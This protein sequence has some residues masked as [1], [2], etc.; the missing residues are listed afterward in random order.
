[1]FHETNTQNNNNVQNQTS[2]FLSHQEKTNTKKNK[3][4]LNGVKLLDKFNLSTKYTILSIVVGT[5]PVLVISCLT[6]SFGNKLISKQIRDFQE[7]QVMGLSN[8]VKSL[9]A[10]SY[11]DMGI[12]S[13]LA[14][15]PNNTNNY[16]GQ[17]S[18]DNLVKSS[19][20]YDSVSVF[21]INGNLIKYGGEYLETQL[22]LTDLNQ[23][24]QHNYPI[25]TPLEKV[26]NVGTVIYIIAPIKDENNNIV[27]IVKTRIPI[28]NLQQGLTGYL[29]NNKQYL[30]LDSAGKII[31]NSSTNSQGNNVLGKDAQTIYPKLSQII[32]SNNI[33]TFSTFS[34]NSQNQELVSYVALTTD[35]PDDLAKMNLRLIVTQSA[36][37]AFQN[38]REFL[39]FIIMATPLMVLCMTLLVAWLIQLITMEVLA[40]SVISDAENQ[41][42]KSNLTGNIDKND[43]K[44]RDLPYNIDNINQDLEL[45]ISDIH[46]SIEKLEKVRMISLLKPEEMMKNVE[47]CGEII[48]NIRF[49]FD[50]LQLAVSLINDA[51]GLGNKSR[52]LIEDIENTVVIEESL[53]IT[54]KKIK[55]LGEYAQQIA[56]MVASISQIAMQTNLLAINAGIEAARFGED[57]EGF[58]VV[59]EEMGELAVRNATTTQEIEQILG[60]LQGG[61]SEVLEVVNITNNQLVASDLKINDGKNNVEEIMDILQQLDAVITSIFNTKTYQ[62]QT[63]QILDINLKEMATVSCNTEEIHQSL[64][65]TLAIYEKI[66]TI[67]Y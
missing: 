31:A 50:K 42:M 65:E 15:F 23:V 16:N 13:N 18:L 43:I 4:W 44:V 5:L 64:E 61:I 46:L 63:S 56:R 2:L 6:Y 1:M 14:N 52:K 45:V 9:I 49:I 55:Y 66:K 47:M 8:K 59:A 28:N 7:T 39:I 3:S 36:S 34:Q 29:D 67:V 41:N 54:T 24:I 58:A 57:G 17:Q 62:L 20:M 30:L 19:K 53:S 26:E 32:A 10:D 25:I 33:E 60:K 48:E 22:N 35:V 27:N 40:K 12:I 11:R 38:Q 21:D 37:V 51:N